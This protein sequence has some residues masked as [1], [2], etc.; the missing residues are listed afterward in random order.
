MPGECEGE[1]FHFLFQIPRSF[2]RLMVAIDFHGMERIE[3]G[4]L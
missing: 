4:S 1:L 2:V 3:S